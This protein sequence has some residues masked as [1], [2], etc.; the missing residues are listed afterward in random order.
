LMP[1]EIQ[2]DAWG[3][4][5]LRGWENMSTLLMKNCAISTHGDVHTTYI[6][7]VPIK[8][9]ESKLKLEFI[10]LDDPN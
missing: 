3:T 4:H 6:Y 10:S 1:R 7:V 9:F 2:H 5:G 8:S